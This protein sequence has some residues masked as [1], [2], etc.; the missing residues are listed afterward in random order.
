VVETVAKRELESKLQLIIDPATN[1]LLLFCI[2]TFY[3]L[4]IT[5][6]VVA[7]A[8]AGHCEFKASMVYSEFQDSQGYID[9]VCLNLK[10]KQISFI[11]HYCV[12]VMCVST[13]AYMP[14]HISRDQ[15]PMFGGQFSPSNLGS[16]DPTE[17]IRLLE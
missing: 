12:C 16:R 17:V 5:S 7:H 2:L 9:R 13:G 8:E 4:S 10:N 6:V 11:Y 15:K 1:Q 3:N 14:W